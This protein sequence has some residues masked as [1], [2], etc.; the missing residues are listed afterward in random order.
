MLY[1]DNLLIGVSDFFLLTRLV[2]RD[3][4]ESED[5]DLLLDEETSCIYT[6][7]LF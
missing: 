2:F 3:M 6:I 1:L 5:Y 7:L 4:L